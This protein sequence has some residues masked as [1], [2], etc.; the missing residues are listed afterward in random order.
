MMICLHIYGTYSA[1]REINDG[2]EERRDEVKIKHFGRSKEMEHSPQTKWLFSGAQKAHPLL[3]KKAEYIVV[4]MVIDL[5]DVR[6]LFCFLHFQNELK[7][8][9][10]SFKVRR[11]LEFNLRSFFL[12]AET[13]LVDHTPSILMVCEFLKGL[14][15]VNSSDNI[16]QCL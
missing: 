6:V 12:N 16:N 9:L 2:S 4:C 1:E 8:I 5:G 13:L 10:I 3:R 11:C 14:S 15:I 7:L